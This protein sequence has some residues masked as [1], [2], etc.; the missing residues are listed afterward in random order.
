MKMVQSNLI[1]V[2]SSSLQSTWALISLLQHSQVLRW[3]LFSELLD[4]FV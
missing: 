3:L 1:L 2:F 4:V